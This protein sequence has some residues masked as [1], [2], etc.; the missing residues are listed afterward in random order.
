[1]EATERGRGTPER[2]IDSCGAFSVLVRGHQRR[3][4]LCAR[5]LAKDGL[6]LVSGWARFGLSL[7]AHDEQLRRREGVEPSL[8]EESVSAI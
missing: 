8:E 5:P 1:M 3:L 6:G 7:D 2:S 4:D